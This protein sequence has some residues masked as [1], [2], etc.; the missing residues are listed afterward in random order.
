MTILQRN[1]LQYYLRSGSPLPMPAAKTPPKSN[2]ANKSHSFD[3]RRI[4][5]ARR[6]T[7]DVIKASG[8]LEYEK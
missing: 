4:K 3:F 5:T 2:S 7:L 6:R 1:K 8:A